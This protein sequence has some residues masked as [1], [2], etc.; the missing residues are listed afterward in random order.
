MFSLVQNLTSAL[1]VHEAKRAPDDSQ[2][3]T[4]ENS[5]YSSVSIIDDDN[6]GEGEQY[7]D[8]AELSV[9]SLIWFF[10]DYFATRL[11]KKD[12][13]APVQSSQTFKP[14]MKNTYSNANE[15]RPSPGKVASLYDK[16]SIS[17]FC[18]VSEN[19]VDGE[20][21]RDEL[22]GL[23]ELLQNLRFL[24]D[25]DVEFLSIRY[26]KPFMGAVADAAEAAKEMS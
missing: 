7:Q 14:W 25:N 17:S 8:G 24:R 2:R 19:Q 5:R 10:E 20:E 23:Y 12:D 15:E 18:R 16:N 6:N 1:K 13:Y 21:V 3:G 26:G 9:Q 22:K 4:K 11:D